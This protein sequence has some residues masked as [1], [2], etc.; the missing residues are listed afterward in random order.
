MIIDYMTKYFT[1]ESEAE[2]PRRKPTART[3]PTS[4]LRMALAK[5][6]EAK[7]VMMEFN[8][9]PA[10]FPHDISVDSNGV[11]WIAEHG[12]NEFGTTKAGVRGLIKEGVGLF[13]SIDPESLKY[14]HYTPPKAKFPA[15]V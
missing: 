12:E 11:A 5:G 15:R 6:P 10:A 4:H 7:F 2:V 3:N 8:L 14:S 9:R 1:Q 13:S